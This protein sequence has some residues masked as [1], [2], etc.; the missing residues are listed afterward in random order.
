M[1]S[2]IQCKLHFHPRWNSASLA[3][4]G[5]KLRGSKLPRRWIGRSADQNMALKRWPSR[6]PV[7]TP[8][9]FFLWG[10]IK[11]KSFGPPLPVSV[12]DLN[13]RIATAAASVDEDMLRCV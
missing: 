4:G 6:S 1:L 5:S 13:Q 12:N 11:D 2:S 7:L 8:C 10:C 3:H 9:D